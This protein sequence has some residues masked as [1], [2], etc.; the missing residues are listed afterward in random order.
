MNKKQIWRHV[1]VSKNV[2]DEI[3][4]I[5]AQDLTYNSKNFQWL[6]K[7]TRPRMDCDWI[8]KTI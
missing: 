7:K 3:K 4:N 8:G 2:D 6:N 1:C 5:A